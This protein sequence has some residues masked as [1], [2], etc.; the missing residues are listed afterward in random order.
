MIFYQTNRS[1]KRGFTLIELSIVL[2]IIGLI[3]GGVLVGRDLIATAAIRAQ[4]SQIENYNTAVNTFRLK[5]GY[6]PG[7]IPEPHASSFGF[8]ARGTNGT[9]PGQGDGNGRIQNYDDAIL[10]GTSLNSDEQIVFWR[11]LSTSKLITGDF[12]TARM[13]SFGSLAHSAYGT[14]GS[15]EMATFIPRAKIWNQASI[16][17]FSGGWQATYGA[18]DGFNYFLL[19]RQWNSLYSAKAT[20]LSAAQAYA[21]DNKIDDGL[22]QYGTV[23]ALMMNTYYAQSYASGGDITEDEGQNSVDGLTGLDGGPVTEYDGLQLQPNDTTCYDN[24]FVL[25]AL[26][27]YSTQWLGGSALNCTLAF[28]FK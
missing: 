14:M 27:Q 13:N 8:V 28:R 17:V 19:A 24:R 3:I 1:D 6:L 25:G 26:A 4:I 20:A 5:Y 18:S 10:Q 11:D 15:D 22:P 16:S 2:V 23:Q 21:I 7:D 12:S 9:N